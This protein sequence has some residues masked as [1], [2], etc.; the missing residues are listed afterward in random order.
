M[1][2][3]EPLPSP[4]PVVLLDVK[5]D[6]SEFARPEIQLA[7]F[8]LPAEVCRL[9]D[10]LDELG[11]AMIESLEVRAGVPRRVVFRTAMP[12]AIFARPQPGDI[13]PGVAHP[14]EF[15]REDSEL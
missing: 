4:V 11:T 2:N 8:A 3:G 12:E 15:G 13:A 9:L 1:K 14:S 5:L 10:R 6:S 7:D